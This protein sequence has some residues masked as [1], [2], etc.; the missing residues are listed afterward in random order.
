MFDKLDSSNFT[1]SIESMFSFSAFRRLWLVFSFLF[2][3]SKY[4][5]H[6]VKIS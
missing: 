1:S 3:I 4:K 5:N 2:L 6:L